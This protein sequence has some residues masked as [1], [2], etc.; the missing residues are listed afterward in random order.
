MG[1]PRL[2]VEVVVLPTGTASR[3]DQRTLA[4]AVVRERAGRL[5]RICSRCGGTDHGQ[6]RIVGGHVSLAYCP[7]LCVV[8]L[9]DAPVGVDVEPAGAAPSGFPDI[10][11]WTRTEAVL[12]AIG[13]GVRRDPATV[14]EVD[15][16]FEPLDLPSPYVGWVAVL[17]VSE[18]SLW[19]APA[20]AVRTA[21]DPAPR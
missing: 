6:P 3:A 4:E 5:T 18:I 19:A 17:G 12:K 1:G 10:D 16:A 11:R 20:A 15:A 7:G 2:N 8:A 9:A 14:G 13:K 21:T